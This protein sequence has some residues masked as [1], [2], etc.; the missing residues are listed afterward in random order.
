MSG[1]I[2]SLHILDANS[3]S[4]IL[5]ADNSH[6]EGWLLI[7]LIASFTAQKVCALMI[8]QKFSF[9][10]VS[11]TLGD[12][13]SKKWLQLMSKRL[14]SFSPQDFDGFRSYF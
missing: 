14:L 4:D 2:S 6:S 7:L 3:L 8:P 1:F 10:F 5:L 11:L 12:V 13:S 9:A